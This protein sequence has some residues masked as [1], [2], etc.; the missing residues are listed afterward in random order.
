MFNDPPSLML[1]KS[2]HSIELSSGVASRAPTAQPF[3]S[4][5]DLAVWILPVTSPKP[6]KAP[7]SQLH[8][9]PTT[10]S[11]KLQYKPCSLS[12]IPLNTDFW[13]NGCDASTE[14]GKT[15]ETATDVIA[16]RLL[17]ARHARLTCLFFLGC[18]PLGYRTILQ[19]IHHPV[20]S[21]RSE[22]ARAVSLLLCTQV[23]ENH[24]IVLE[25]HWNIISY[26][27]QL[28]AKLA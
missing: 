18:A 22:R 15:Q 6:V 7:G 16:G 5:R 10:F 23:W 14:R 28:S 12:F 25:E 21:M 24:L 19:L 4:R 9:M 17:W 8:N 27:Q 20:P 2:I 13:R 3:P 11:L 1:L 26:P